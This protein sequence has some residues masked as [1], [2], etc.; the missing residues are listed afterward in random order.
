MMVPAAGT[1]TWWWTAGETAA[2]GTPR[3][4]ADPEAAVL[5]EWRMR[6]ER[7][8][9]SHTCQAWSSHWGSRLTEAEQLQWGPPTKH[10]ELEEKQWEQ[11]FKLELS[12]L[13]A[14]RME[15]R[16]QAYGET[17]QTL[18]AELKAFRFEFAEHRRQM[19]RDRQVLWSLR[20]DNAKLWEEIAA[21]AEAVSAVELDMTAEEDGKAEE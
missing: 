6:L 19:K 13:D 4:A 15:S 2:C 3:A 9:R 10:V 14:E 5:T 21:A 16:Q 12:G 17:L 11:A 8:V 1:A 7:K 18:S 20:D